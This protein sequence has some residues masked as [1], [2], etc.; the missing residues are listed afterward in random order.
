MSYSVSGLR[1]TISMAGTIQEQVVF[2]IVTLVIFIG[3]G[4]MAYRPGVGEEESLG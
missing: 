4:V 1:Q 2:L 3:L